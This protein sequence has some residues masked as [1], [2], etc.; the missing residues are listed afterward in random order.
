MV[1]ADVYVQMVGLN[2]METLLAAGGWKCSFH[3]TVSNDGQ[4]H[5]ELRMVVWLSVEGRFAA[6]RPRGEAR[7]GCMLDSDATGFKHV[8]ETESVLSP[9]WSL[10]VRELRR[11]TLS[12]PSMMVQMA[13][14]AKYH[15]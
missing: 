13:K 8:T 14:R 1:V 6:G 9:I 11:Q 10:K 3:L 15:L 5:L 12:G 4:M 2:D 7:A